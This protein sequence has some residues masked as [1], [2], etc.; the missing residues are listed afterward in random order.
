[1]NSGRVKKLRSEKGEHVLKRTAILNWWKK[2][3]R[4]EKYKRAV[5]N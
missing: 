4:V 2:R 3:E 1:M 5:D